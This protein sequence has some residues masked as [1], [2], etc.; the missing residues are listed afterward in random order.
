M[1]CA[2]DDYTGPLIS[3]VIRI[4]RHIR[5]MHKW[6]LSFNSE[7]IRAGGRVVCMVGGS[8]HRSLLVNYPC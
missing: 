5:I 3:Y 4:C 2:G 8:S 7:H 6:N 1:L